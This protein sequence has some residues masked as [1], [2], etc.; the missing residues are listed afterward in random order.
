[1]KAYINGMYAEIEWAMTLAAERDLGRMPSS[2]E[3]VKYGVC[4]VHPDGRQEWKWRGETV[5]VMHPWVGP[6]PP[7]VE[8]VN[9]SN[10][11]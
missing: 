9:A 4:A 8:I 5:A 3:I 7:R 1:M 6:V 11:P 2:D 10:L